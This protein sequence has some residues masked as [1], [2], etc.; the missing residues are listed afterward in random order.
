MIFLPSASLQ[1][2]QGICP[3]YSSQIQLQ[4]L[5]MFNFFLQMVPKETNLY[6]VYFC[7][8]HVAH[9]QKTHLEPL[10]VTQNHTLVQ[11]PGYRSQQGSSLEPSGC[12][13]NYYFPW[14]KKGPQFWAGVCCGYPGAWGLE[15]ELKHFVD[16]HP[17]PRGKPNT[18]FSPY[19][20]L[21]CLNSF[22]CVCLV[23]FFL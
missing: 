14:L 12:I 7:T 10:S 17:D 22:R 9:C 11:E 6:L 1:W 13:R 4:M 23:L 15:E 2:A 20:V 21:E 19:Q 8:Q 5:L 18:P 16:F 3:N